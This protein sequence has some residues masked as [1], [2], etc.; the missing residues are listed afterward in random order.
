M[1]YLESLF[2]HVPDGVRGL[3]LRDGTIKPEYRGRICE[4]TAERIRH[5]VR[6]EFRPVADVAEEYGIAKSTVRRMVGYIRTKP[7]KP[8]KPK[9][10]QTTG[11]ITRRMADGA[12]WTV[13][14]L[15]N[16]TGRTDDSI[17]GA[18][19]RGAFRRVGTTI[20]RISG[21][22]SVAWRIGG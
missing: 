7:K 19:T 16:A 1:S 4:E 6:R 15:Q 12:V 20:C 9:P 17:R 3:S 18:L 14:E 21:R 10:T 13:R 22:P 11:D 5:A 8:R 2:P